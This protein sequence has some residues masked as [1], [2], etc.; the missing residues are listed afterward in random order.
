LGRRCKSDCVEDFGAYNLRESYSE[1][2][3]LPFNGLFS[4]TKVLEAESL[5]QC[6]LSQM[7]YPVALEMPGAC[8]L[9]MF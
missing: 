7:N 9:K 2:T 5:S 6:S 3:H 1:T 8:L 4:L